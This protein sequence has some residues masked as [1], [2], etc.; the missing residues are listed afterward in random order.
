M[1]KRSATQASASEHNNGNGRIRHARV[2][3]DAWDR[4][5]A[6]LRLTHSNPVEAVI[7]D[8][9]LADTVRKFDCVHYETCLD[10]ADV[11]NWAGFG[12]TVCRVFEAAPAPSRGV[13]PPRLRLV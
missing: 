2:A 4:R 7:Y 5:G 3:R 1:T 12:C 13:R 9:D 8:C 6:L 10:T 11:L